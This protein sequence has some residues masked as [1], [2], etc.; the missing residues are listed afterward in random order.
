MTCWILSWDDN[1]LE[2]ILNWT[3]EQNKYVEASLKEEHIANPCYYQ[4]D[5]LAMRARFNNHRNP[6]IYAIN[7]ADEIDAEQIIQY[8]EDNA[9]A[10]KDLIRRKSHYKIW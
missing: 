2:T 3:E 5:R 1:G 6:E 8:F 10:F 7:I 9:S 4:V